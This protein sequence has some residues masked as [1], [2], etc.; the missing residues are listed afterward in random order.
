MTNNIEKRDLAQMFSCELKIF[1]NVTKRV[2]NR[3]L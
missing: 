2:P 1:I 3:L